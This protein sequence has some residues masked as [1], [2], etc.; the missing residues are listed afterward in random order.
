[1]SRSCSG[2]RLIICSTAAN[3]TN[4]PLLRLPG[5]L[6]NRIY[7]FAAGGFVIVVKDENG[8]VSI[9]GPRPPF[10]LTYRLAIAT[11]PGTTEQLE[12]YTNVNGHSV[13][14]KTVSKAEHV[15]N[16]FTIARVCRQVSE[17]TALLQ[18]KENVFSFNTGDALRSFSALLRSAQRNA[19]N[20][21]S[22]ETEYLRDQLRWGTGYP[23]SSF[24]ISMPPFRK[25]LP[26]LKNIFVAPKSLQSK[27]V[28]QDFLRFLRPSAECD[29][30]LLFRCYD[31][32]DATANWEDSSSCRLTSLSDH[33]QETAALVGAEE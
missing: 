28:E 23:S 13:R 5:E 25:M 21:I 1:M 16:I 31:A 2:T 15:S 24:S 4:S 9:D 10:K 3:K 11:T 27:S 20:T 12:N 30:G 26:S 29:I 7:S 32:L 22:I 14:A 33:G 8:P 18:Y 19:I 17:E 6:R